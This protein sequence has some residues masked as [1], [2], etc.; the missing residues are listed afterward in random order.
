VVKITEARVFDPQESARTRERRANR[1][2]RIGNIC[3]AMRDIDR[4]IASALDRK[5]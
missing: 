5:T 3:G 4:M 2:R 1:I